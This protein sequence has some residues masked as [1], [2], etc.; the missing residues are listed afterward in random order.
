M[1]G[2][3]EKQEMELANRTADARHLTEITFRLKHVFFLYG[4]CKKIGK[5]SHSQQCRQPSVH[6]SLAKAPAN[7][8]YKFDK[9]HIL[10]G[11]YFHWSATNALLCSF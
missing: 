2:D 11:N 5:E 1:A 6:A 10:S 3:V 9:A 7:F 8:T 4:G